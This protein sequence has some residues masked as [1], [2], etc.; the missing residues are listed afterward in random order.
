[1]KKFIVSGICTTIVCFL[2][3]SFTPDNNVAGTNAIYAG[4]TSYQDT[5]HKK[6]KKTD[7]TKSDTTTTSTKTKKADKGKHPVK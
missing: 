2:L 3:S 6:T 1:M 7:K 5:T 4:N